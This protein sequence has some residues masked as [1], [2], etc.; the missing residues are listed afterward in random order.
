MCETGIMTICGY[1]YICRVPM[2]ERNVYKVGKTK[3]S[4][5]KRM[6]SYKKGTRL[7]HSFPVMDCD[8][9]ELKV[10]EAVRRRFLCVKGREY[11]KGALDEI[12]ELVKEIVE[13]FLIPEGE[14]EYEIDRVMGK[15]IV[16]RKLE[17]LVKWKHFKEATWEP[18]E[19]LRACAEAIDD[20]EM[21]ALMLRNED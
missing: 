6:A 20:F 19:N 16:G 3:T 10:V 5:E 2:R 4:L 21:A 15:R 12:E 18:Y 9:A 7:L 13:P 1:I 17:Y 8:A 14:Q 11:F